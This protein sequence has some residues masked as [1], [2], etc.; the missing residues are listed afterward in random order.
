M[1]IW[2]SH[3]IA[4]LRQSISGTPAI[5]NPCR[6][7][8]CLHSALRITKECPAGLRVW[9]FAHPETIADSERVVYEPVIQLYEHPCGR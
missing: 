5:Q 4:M 9:D 3:Q 2:K 6:N 1:V 7:R 8:A